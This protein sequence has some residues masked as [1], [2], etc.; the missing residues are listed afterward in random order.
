MYRSSM[1]ILKHFKFW[2]QRK[3]RSGSVWSMSFL[4]CKIEFYARISIREKHAKNSYHI[5]YEM[6]YKQYEII[7]I[8]MC[9]MMTYHFFS[10]HHMRKFIPS[11]IH[12]M[13]I[14]LL[15]FLQKQSLTFA[16]YLFGI[17]TLL[18]GLGLKKKM[19]RGGPRHLL[20]HASASGCHTLCRSSFTIFSVR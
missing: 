19:S 5:C 17:G 14:I 8:S 3:M 7:L 11:S 10:F 13:M 6:M 1:T 4:T 9:G 15:L 20:H 12:F 2:S 18:T 16:V